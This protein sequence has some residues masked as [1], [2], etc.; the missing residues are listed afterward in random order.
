MK[1][2]AIGRFAEVSGPVYNRRPIAEAPKR[3]D[4]D[5]VK[6]L[7]S[8]TL[9]VTIALASIVIGAAIAGALNPDGGAALARLFSFGS[10]LIAMTIMG[11]RFPF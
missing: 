10:T 9:S 11:K 5:D 8:V 2:W 4:N 1:L 6:K 7:R 3:P